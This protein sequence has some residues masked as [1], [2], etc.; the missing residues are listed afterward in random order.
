[1]KN[2]SNLR[3]CYWKTCHGKI[4]HRKISF[5]FKTVSAADVGMEI[6]QFS[7]NHFTEKLDRVFFEVVSK[8]NDHVLILKKP[9]KND[10][11]VDLNIV[12]GRFDIIVKIFI[13]A[14]KY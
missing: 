3:Q 2:L 1:M 4:C 5:V 8:Q 10:M 7:A 14:S 9:L 6:Y 13:F 12:K 11:E